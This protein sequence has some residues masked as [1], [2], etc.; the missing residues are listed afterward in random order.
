MK[1]VRILY[2][3]EQ[4]FPR[5]YFHFNATTDDFLL[6]QEECNKRYKKKGVK[7]ELSVSEVTSMLYK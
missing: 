4:D 5:V 7:L 1:Q 6:L 3:V 2:D